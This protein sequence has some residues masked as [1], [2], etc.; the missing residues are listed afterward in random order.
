MGRVR[1]FSNAQSRR[2]GSG[3]GSRGPMRVTGK[4]SLDANGNAFL[5]GYI[6]DRIASAIDRYDAGF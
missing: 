6:D 3:G 5:D 1:I 2:M 4:L